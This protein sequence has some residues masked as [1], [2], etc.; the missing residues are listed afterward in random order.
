PKVG[1]HTPPPEIMKVVMQRTR[2]QLQYERLARNETS[3]PT[4][5]KNQSGSNHPIKGGATLCALI[6]FAY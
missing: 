6:S 4:S 5:L 1:K 3:C 2:D